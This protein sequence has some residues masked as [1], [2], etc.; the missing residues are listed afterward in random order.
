MQPSGTGSLPHQRHGGK[1]DKKKG[2][3]YQ[4]AGGLQSGVDAAAEL[5][6]DQRSEIDRLL[7]AFRKL[8]T[9]RA[10]LFATTHAAWNDF[11]LRD[12]QPTDEEIINE[13]RTAW[14]PEKAKFTPDRIGRCIDWIRQENFT[15]RGIGR[16][17]IAG[18]GAKS[19]RTKKST[20]ARKP[21]QQPAK[22]KSA[23]RKP[24][25]TTDDVMVEFRAALRGAGEVKETDLLRDV[26]HRLG[27]QRLSKN[28]RTELT[29][30]LRA[31]I[32]RKIA[33]RDGDHLTCPTSF[34]RSYESA[35]LRQKLKS[36]MTKGRKY[37]R[38][39]VTKALA[40][41]LGLRNVTPA[42]RKQMKSV[43]NSAIRGNTVQAV[44]RNQILRG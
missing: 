10:E 17:T 43:Y 7:G 6:G 12:H 20:P 40:T 44:G 18:P 13:V 21:K 19:I 35:F 28:L 15:P 5:L 34:F 29:G 31:A 42:M 14:H 23:N 8:N 33:E 16:P 1:S 4:P 41:H 25:F 11:L 39:E 9:E 30:H 32:R 22:Q 26:A 27:Y 2:Y 3:R 38:D 36:V 24:N 37:T